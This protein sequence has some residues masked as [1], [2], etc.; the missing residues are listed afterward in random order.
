MYYLIE[1]TIID[2]KQWQSLLFQTTLNVTAVC[3]FWFFL[4]KILCVKDSLN[5]EK[6]C[7]TIINLCIHVKSKTHFKSYSRD[8]L[9][10]SWVNTSP[11]LY[12]SL[13]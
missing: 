3:I 2:T 11:V 5:E 6:L 12:T 4:K 1:L 8:V 9:I 13:Q 7:T 10:N